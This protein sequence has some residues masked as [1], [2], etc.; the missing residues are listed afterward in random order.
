[1]SR[2][3]L[4]KVLGQEFLDLG[5]NVGVLYYSEPPNH[6]EVCRDPVCRASSYTV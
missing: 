1:M 4:R 6:K 3:Q 5:S 2:V